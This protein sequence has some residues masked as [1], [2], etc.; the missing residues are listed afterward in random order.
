MR[1]QDDAA[2]TS[3]ADFDADRKAVLDWL[4]AEPSVAPGRLGTIAVCCYPTGLHNGRV[5]KDPD[6]GT[7]E[8]AG[9][10]RGELLV[11]FG[12]TDPHVPA[13]GR[14]KVAD[15]LTAARVKYRI[16]LAPGEH[17]FMRDEGARYDPESADGVWREAIGLFRRVFA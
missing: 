4:E 11:V 9:E 10:A 8:R 7:L 13:E 2:R 1:G 15:A 3:V 5:G 12:E 14:Q 16:H 6:A 17:A